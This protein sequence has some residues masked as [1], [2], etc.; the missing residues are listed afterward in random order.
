MIISGETL[1]VLRQIKGIKQ[2]TIAKDLGISQPAYSQIERSNYIDCQR[3]E[4]ILSHM[5]YSSEDFKEFIKNYF[6][7]EKISQVS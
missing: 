3:F 5:G 2:Q 4:Q 1:R 7:H 6:R